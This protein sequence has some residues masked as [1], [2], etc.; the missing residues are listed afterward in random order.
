MPQRTHCITLL[1]VRDGSKYCVW[2]FALIHPTYSSWVFLTRPS[3]IRIQSRI[4]CVP[5]RQSRQRQRQTESQRAYSRSGSAFVFDRR[6][7]AIATDIRFARSMYGCAEALDALAGRY[8][9]SSA[10]RWDGRP[11][12]VQR[13]RGCQSADNGGGRVGVALGNRVTIASVHKPDRR[14]ARRRRIVIAAPGRV[15]MPL[16][17]GIL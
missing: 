17:A 15:R 4:E 9:G 6:N 14:Q 5:C 8:V 12:S 3:V 1:S 2:S 7:P 11:V 16:T 13:H 10:D